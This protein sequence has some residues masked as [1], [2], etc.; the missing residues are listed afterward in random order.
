MTDYKQSFRYRIP[1]QI[2][3]PTHIYLNRS[4]GVL[5]FRELVKHKLA[6]RNTIVK[7][8][9]IGLNMHLS[10]QLVMYNFALWYPS[11][12]SFQQSYRTNLFSSKHYNGCIST[13]SNKLSNMKYRPMHTVRDTYRNIAA[14]VA[15][16]GKYFQFQGVLSLEFLNRIL[17]IF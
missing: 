3:I 13:I 15:P 1:T 8:E 17:F 5:Q 14:S 2:S 16:C 4:L 11:A 7:H 10:I 6:I 9:N 12:L